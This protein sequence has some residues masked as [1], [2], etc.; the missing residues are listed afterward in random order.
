MV[1]QSAGTGSP[2]LGMLSSGWWTCSDQSWLSVHHR[3]L[4]DDCH[5]VLGLG[6]EG[7]LLLLEGLLLLLRVY[8]LTAAAPAG[9]RHTRLVTGRKENEGPKN[10]S[11]ELN[12]P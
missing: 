7:L 6:E 1:I 8:V 10:L 5:L 9:T 2:T 11:R 3:R 12:S 4:S